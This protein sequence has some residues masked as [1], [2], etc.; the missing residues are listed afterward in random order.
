MKRF[1]AG[2]FRYDKDRIFKRLKILPENENVY[3]YANGVFPQLETIARTEMELLCGYTV[4]PNTLELDSPEMDSCDLLAVC[5]ASCTDRI[6]NKI[7]RMMEEGDFLEGYILNDLANDILFSAS[8]DMNCQLYE[9]MKAM[10]YH[11]TSRFTPGENHLALEHQRTFL[12][13]LKKRCPELP[14]Q[15]TESYM[16]H[17]E[18]AMLYAY[19]GGKHLPDRSITHDCANC[20]NTNCFYRSKKA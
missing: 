16:L 1:T 10:G 20:S 9:E 3:E 6:V 11:L 8:D 14:I 5:L 18:K 17:P 15:L 2:S 12:N 13:V 7:A 4:I 19:G